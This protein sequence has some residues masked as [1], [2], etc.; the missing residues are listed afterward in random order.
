MGRVGE[1]LALLSLRF[2][3]GRLEEMLI[4]AASSTPCEGIQVPEGAGG[5]GLV[6]QKPAHAGSRE[7]GNLL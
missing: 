6:K 3:S 7:R 2:R 5:S 4:C 1:H